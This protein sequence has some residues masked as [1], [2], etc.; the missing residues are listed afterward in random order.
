MVTIP[1]LIRYENMHVGTVNTSDD[2]TVNV[3]G[4]IP[5]DNIVFISAETG[6]SV[7]NGA[8]S[9]TETTTQGKKQWTAEDCYG[10][11]NTDGSLSGTDST[12]TIA[13]SGEAKSAGTFEGTVAYTAQCGVH[14][15]GNYLKYLNDHNVFNQTYVTTQDFTLSWYNYEKIGHWC[16]DTNYDA[17]LQIDVKNFNHVFDTAHK[18]SIKAHALKSW[19]TYG[20]AY[21]PVNLTLITDKGSYNVPNPPQYLMEADYDND[22][23][24]SLDVPKGETLQ[25]IRVKM[26][27]K[28]V[29]GMRAYTTNV[30]LKNVEIS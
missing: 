23:S 1:T 9:I 11:M 5:A 27:E 22:I 10:S 17:T 24:L 21:T 20:G 14:V 16:R 4:T 12:D 15:E 19:T 3:K 29:Y 8:E 6:N 18:V 30:Y 7:A 28:N 25:T 13:L 2:Y 26:R